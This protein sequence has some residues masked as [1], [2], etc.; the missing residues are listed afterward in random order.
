MGTDQAAD[1]QRHG[2]EHRIP[3]SLATAGRGRMRTG[4]DGDRLLDRLD[5]VELHDDLARALPPAGARGRWPAGSAGRGRRPRTARPGGRRACAL[6]R[7]ARAG[8]SGGR[9]A[10]SGSSRSGSTSSA[11]LAGGTRGSRGR[12]R[13]QHRVDHL[14][15]VQALERDPRVGVHRHER[16]HVAAHVVESDR[17]DRRDADGALDTLARGCELRPGA[18]EVRQ[19]G[20]AGLVE[21]PAPPRSPGA[22]RRERSGAGRRGRSR[23]AGLPGS[24]PTG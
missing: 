19:Q 12:P 2:A 1:R 3:T 20:P 14:V 9:R 16:L 21:G 7:R 22:A 18:V 11:R 13:P 8:G 10:P 23:A 5:V 6:R 24:P 15:R 17:V 4:G